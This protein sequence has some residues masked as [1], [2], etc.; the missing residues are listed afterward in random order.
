MQ[1]FIILTRYN[2]ILGVL[3]ESNYRIPNQMS[4]CLVIIFQTSAVTSNIA[5]ANPM[6]QLARYDV[7]AAHASYM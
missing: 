3:I 2:N 5:S 6:I 7:G 4:N 1:I